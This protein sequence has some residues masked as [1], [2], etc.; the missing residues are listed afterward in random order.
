MGEKVANNVAVRTVVI[1]LLKKK[2]ALFV[3]IK[4]DGHLRLTFIPSNIV[5]DWIKP[6]SHLA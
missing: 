6:L 5:R 4:N 2:Y 1:K 3:Y